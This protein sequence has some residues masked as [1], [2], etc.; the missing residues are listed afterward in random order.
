MKALENLTKDEELQGQD[1]GEGGKEIAEASVG[2]G[3][4]PGGTC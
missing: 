3:F 1:L 2:V 4:P